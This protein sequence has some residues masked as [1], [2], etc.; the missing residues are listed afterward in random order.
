MLN[1]PN[2]FPQ[3]E[4]KVLRKDKMRSGFTLCNLH[5]QEQRVPITVVLLDSEGN[6]RWWFQHG[7]IPDMRGDID[8]RAL[9]EGVLIG[10][11]NRLQK[12]KE[13]PPVLVGWNGKI[14]G[15]GKIVNHHHIHGT[16]EG[17][18]MFLIEEER[19][20]KHLSMTIVG[21]VI[22]EY[23]PQSDS[24]VW[25]WH[26]FDHLTPKV[27]RGDWSHCNTIEPD[28]RDGS[29]YLSAR[30]LNSIFKIDQKTGK[31]I[32][33]LGENGNF[34]IA[35]EDRFYHQHSPEIQPNGNI[36]LFDNGALRPEE[37][38]GEFSRTLEL[39]LDEK[40]MKAKVVW[41]WHNNPDLF[42]PIWG[43]ADRL[44]NGNTLMVF[45]N[46][47]PIRS[48]LTT[49]SGRKLPTQTSRL[50]EVTPS[51]EKVWELE[52]SPPQWGVYR[53]ERID[54][55]DDIYTYITEEPGYFL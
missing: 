20:F 8:V 46:R 26:L 21:D 55:K 11:T 36:L 33:R 3:I 16:P 12:E 22:I 17:N 25:E 14:L 1:L 47:V 15:Q 52:V 43:D 49:I 34:E 51:G 7:N 39:S 44:D 5:N 35:P 42:T 27:R 2:V 38:G 41:S 18:Y 23:D 40:A 45:G 24:V 37:L 4:V 31:I 32:W 9:P 10:G 28:P 6:V 19:Y 53:A 54:E 29:L 50:I 30:N 48:G 13:V